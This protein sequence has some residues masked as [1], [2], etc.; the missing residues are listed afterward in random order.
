LEKYS[1]NSQIIRIRRIF[2][3]YTDIVP[4]GGH[5]AL[6]YGAAKVSASFSHFAAAPLFG[7][8]RK[9]APEG[10]RKKGAAAIIK[11]LTLQ[12]G[13]ERNRIPAGAGLFAALPE[14]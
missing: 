1:A 14:E 10:L 11:Y 12:M 5:K 4:P 2:P 7:K 9:C 3:Y 13:A 8:K 6:P